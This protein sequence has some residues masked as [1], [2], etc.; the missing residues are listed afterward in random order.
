MKLIL[1][2]SLPSISDPSSEVSPRVVDPS[3][4]SLSPG[5]SSSPEFACPPVNVPRINPESA[6]NSSQANVQD[7]ELHPEDR[8]LES[9]SEQSCKDSAEDRTPHQTRSG[10]KVAPPN[11]FGQWFY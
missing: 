5:S 4:S 2:K 6:N 1:V 3:E 11:R 7:D 9:F 10:R 8:L